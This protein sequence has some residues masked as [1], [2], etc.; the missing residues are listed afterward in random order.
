M[1][2]QSYRA[3]GDA[4]AE[5]FI[6]LDAFPLDGRDQAGYQDVLADARAQLDEDGC[7][8]LRGFVRDAM[9]PVLA[10]EAD[11][12]A[13]HAHRSFSRTNAY[14]SEDDPTLAQNDPRRRFYDRSNAFVPADHFGADS[15]LRAIYEYTPFQQFIR[16]ALQAE[17]FFRYADPLADVIV[18]VVEEG[19]GFPW[20]FDTNNF[21]VT[22]A[23]QNGEEG[24]MFE[25]AP[26]L[27]TA[28]AECFEA[29]GSVLD[30]TSDKVRTLPL[31]P[32]DL[33][34]F[35]GRY[36]L[37]RVTPVQGRRPR[38]VGIFSFVEM[39]GMVGSVERTRQLYGRV[40]PIHHERAGHRGD[41]LK[42]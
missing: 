1:G 9:I 13:P 20:H 40:L 28:D 8:I 24:G 4:R 7:C 30:E 18:N 29:V 22:L 17:N 19:G 21:T 42:D 38:Y 33:Q 27:R 41:N 14:F 35:K 16:A 39:E 5:D 37:H 12:V 34:I 25:Y 26:N 2:Q 31:T 15:G 23:I 3:S 11:R 32:G 10:A 6:N 36:S